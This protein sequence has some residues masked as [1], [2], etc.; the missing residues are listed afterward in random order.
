MD[1]DYLQIH[2]LYLFAHFCI[3]HKKGLNIVLRKMEEEGR[4]KIKTFLLANTMWWPDVISG[5]LDNFN[6]NSKIIIIK[7]L[8]CLTAKTPGTFGSSVEMGG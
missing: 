5:G 1:I 6:Y 7:Y 3:V 4:R 2:M 8:K